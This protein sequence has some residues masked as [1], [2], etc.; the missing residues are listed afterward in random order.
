MDV[1]HGLAPSPIDG[2]AAVTVGFFD[3]VHLGHRALLERT[4]A[5]ARERSL[6]S[7]ALTFD[8]HPREILTPGNEPRLLT[9]LERRIELIGQS[10]IDRLVVLAFTEELSQRSA[11][12]FVDEVLVGAVGVRHAIVGANFTFGHRALGTVE[13]LEELGGERGFSVETMGLLELDG[14][15]VSSSSIREAL[16][17]GDLAWPERALGRR[18]AV[19]G[20]VVSGAGRGVGLGY[21]TANLETEPRLL[22]PGNGIYAGAASIDSGTK[23]AAI[24]VG[25]NPQFGSEPLH[26]EAYLLDFHGDL[27]GRELRVEFWERLRDEATFGSV[28]ELRRAI[29]DDVQRTREIVRVSEG[30][31]A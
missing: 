16:A 17:G 2:G 20:R 8:R 31:S 3:G 23:V 1:L 27:R 9:T 14:R 24:S 11:Q 29:A 4:V 30:R 28:E 25:T 21:P 7:V 22:L 15:P 6:R 18:Y 12:W 26:V 13:V 19:E 5:A 10:G